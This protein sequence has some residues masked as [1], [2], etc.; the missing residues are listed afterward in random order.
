[1]VSWTIS[2]GQEDGS[3]VKYQ[4]VLENIYQKHCEVLDLT[5]LVTT[6]QVVYQHESS[7]YIY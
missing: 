6:D 2:P 1:M 3:A 4:P 7:A 5:P